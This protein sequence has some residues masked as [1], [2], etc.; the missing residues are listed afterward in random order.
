MWEF[1]FG[2][3][4]GAL[5]GRLI[6]IQNSKSKDVTTQVDEVMI[7]QPTKPI[8]IPDRKKKFIPGHLANFWGPDSPHGSGGNTTNS[9]SK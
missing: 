3:L 7:P 9:Y 1:M 6:S 2:F 8:L 4:A 5:T